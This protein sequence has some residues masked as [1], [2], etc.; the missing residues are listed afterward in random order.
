MDWNV[1]V[2]SRFLEDQGSLVE[3]CKRL[4]GAMLKVLLSK[5]SWSA[6]TSRGNLL[7]E[8]IVRLVGMDDFQ[9][10]VLLEPMSG[11]RFS[12][13]RDGES[14]IVLYLGFAL[15]VVVHL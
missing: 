11:G 9:A 2:F 6:G 5:A 10:R 13:I 1:V 8:H 12:L 4:Q 15:C 3:R 14:S 7:A